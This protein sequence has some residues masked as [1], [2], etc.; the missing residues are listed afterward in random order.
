MEKLNCVSY[1]SMDMAHPQMQS[2]DVRRVILQGSICP[3][4][5]GQTLDTR[6]DVE[7]TRRQSERGSEG[8]KV[9][10]DQEKAKR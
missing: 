5:G 10:D 7:T 1:A 2:L 9:L 8:T 6:K 4:L 3:L